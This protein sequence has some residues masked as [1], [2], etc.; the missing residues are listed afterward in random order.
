MAIYALD[1]A[2]CVLLTEACKTLDRI[3]AIEAELARDGL[4]LT[5]SRGQLPRAHPLL[6]ALTEAQKTVSRLVAELALPL[7]GEQVGR[8]RSPQQKAA[9]GAR[10]GRDAGCA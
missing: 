1:P 10:W 3:D 7:P 9:A 2:E 4:T 6:Y 5:G 8:R